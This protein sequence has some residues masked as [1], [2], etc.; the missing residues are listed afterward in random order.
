M[1]TISTLALVI[2]LFLA[3]Q[4]APARSEPTLMR[5]VCQKVSEARN[6]DS[7][8][9]MVIIVQQKNNDIYDGKVLAW[10]LDPYYTETIPFSVTVFEPATLVHPS[11]SYK[12]MAAELM[13]KSD[14][15]TYELDAVG[16]RIADKIWI[17]WGVPDTVNESTYKHR[18]YYDPNRP[19]Y[20]EYD[21]TDDNG[22][23]V[24][25]WVH[26]E[27]PYTIPVQ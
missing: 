12:E 10:R 5:L 26:C 7:K 16:E 1:K 22:K 3:P 25:G 13:A 27:L 23:D 9:D 21:Y 8:T 4:E 19:G 2:A 11:K 14:D 15:A 18:L 24:W 20:H 6:M 17:Y